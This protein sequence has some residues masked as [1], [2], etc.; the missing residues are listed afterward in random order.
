[1]WWKVREVKIKGLIRWVLWTILSTLGFAVSEKGSP[2]EGVTQRKNAICCDF[3]RVC[4][5]ARAEATTRV[6]QVRDEGSV[7]RLNAKLRW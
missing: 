3:Y 2:L 6:I 4:S 1:M 7:A 5:W